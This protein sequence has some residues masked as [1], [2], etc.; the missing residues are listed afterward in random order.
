MIDLKN[1]GQDHLKTGDFRK[2]REGGSSPL[3]RG[4]SS[5]K[6]ESWNI[7]KVKHILIRIQFVH[8][9]ELGKSRFSDSKSDNLK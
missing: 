3:K 2:E 7:C 8:H 1:L 9:I 4:A 5:S 6:R